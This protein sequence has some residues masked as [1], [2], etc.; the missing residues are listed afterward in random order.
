MATE[1]DALARLDPLWAIL[2]RPEARDGGWSV[3]EFFATGETEIDAV[4][5][6][7]EAR[8]AHWRVAIDFGCGVGRLT[9][10]LGERFGR[11]HGVDASAEMIA[12]ARRLN[13]DRPNCSF[14]VADLS[15][16]ES[17]SA[18]FVYSSFVLQHLRSN[19]EIETA[20]GEF[21]RVVAPGGRVVFQLPERLS[22]RRRLQ[23]RRRLFALL[24]RLGASE[25]WL[26]TRARLHP[27][28]LRGLDEE[29]VRAVVSAARGTVLRCERVDPAADLGGVRYYATSTMDRDGRSADR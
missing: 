22:F 1:W 24:S 14:E 12:Q 25:R 23:P 11:C 29:R 10:A 7:A 28:S 17:G 19:R 16:V 4:F 15:G 8:P 5:S 6:H 21:L 13:A 20:L 9:R 26:Y 27:V 2:S 3:A 18:D